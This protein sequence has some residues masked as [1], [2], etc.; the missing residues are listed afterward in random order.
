[1]LLQGCKEGRH[2]VLIDSCF[3]LGVGCVLVCFILD[4][5]GAHLYIGSD[6]LAYQLKV[7]DG[8]E[9]EIDSPI[10]CLYCQD[11]MISVIDG[12]SHHL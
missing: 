11:S 5:L 1:M 12:A 9:M 4:L 7:F 2:L 3:D 10:G 6:K 8:V